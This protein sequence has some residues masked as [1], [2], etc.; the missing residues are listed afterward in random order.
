MGE[1]VGEHNYP[2]YAAQL[3]RLVVPQGRLLLQQMSRGRPG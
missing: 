3:H 2:E 1:H